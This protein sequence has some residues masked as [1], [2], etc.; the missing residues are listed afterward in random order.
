MYKFQVY[1]IVIHKFLGSMSFIIM[2]I[3]ILTLHSGN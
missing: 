3:S 2:T 1:S